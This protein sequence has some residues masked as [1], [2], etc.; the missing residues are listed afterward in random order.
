MHFGIRTEDLA[1][2]ESICLA[3]GLDFNWLKDTI[4]NEYHARKVDVIEISDAD[5]EAIVEAAI[6]KIKQ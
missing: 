1:M 6:Q 3:E 4:L 2:I 5:A